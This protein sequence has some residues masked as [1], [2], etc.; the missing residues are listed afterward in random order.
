MSESQE[1][2][3][4]RPAATRASAGA[5]FADPDSETT[6]YEGRVPALYS[7]WRW[8]IAVL[9]LG[10]GFLWFYAQSLA[11]HVRVT[12]QRV[13]RKTGIFT[14]RTDYFELYRVQDIVV[15]EPF[16]ERVLGFGRLNLISSDRTDHQLLLV[17]LRDANRLGDKVRHAVERQKAARRVTT[18]AEA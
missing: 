6:L 17:G 9:T 8:V 7:L 1:A 3:A 2:A 4:E 5:H 10:L 12:D 15:E 14:K 11:L 16:A 18:L 13:V